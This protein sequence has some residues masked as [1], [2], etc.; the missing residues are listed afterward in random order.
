MADG[1]AHHLH[2][3]AGDV[4]GYALLP[5]NPDHVA[6]LAA[7]LDDPVFV[8]RNREFETWRGTLDRETVVVTSTGVGGPSTAL[9]VEELAALG[10]HTMIRVG[11]SGSLRPDIGN[12][13]LAVVTAAI[14][15]EGTT[16][17]YLPVEFPAVASIDVVLA[18][19]EAAVAGGV[20]HRR[21]IVH[22]KDS[23][24]GEMEPERMPL[25]AALVERLDIW[26]RGGAISSEM[27]TAAVL[28]VGSV[29]DVRTGGV[30]LMWSED[31][32]R[33]GGP[34]PAVE[35]LF[36]TAVGALRRLVAAHVEAGAA[37][38]A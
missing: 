5:N 21:G 14:R 25:A 1:R 28:V 2:L 29:L 16:R 36:A 12:G 11:V 8:A 18:L 9:A 15:D 7:H 32:I 23:Y 31:A 4:G 38:A 37:G 26:R 19:Q 35:P 30:V 20:P 6:A 33:D 3:T 22:T 34:A 10:V 24:Y 17:Q 27:E 13:E